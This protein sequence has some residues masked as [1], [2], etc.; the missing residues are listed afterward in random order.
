[1]EIWPSTVAWPP[2]G[3]LSW[4]LGGAGGK[5]VGRPGQ[6]RGSVLTVPSERQRGTPEQRKKTLGYHFLIRQ[7][8]DDPGFAQD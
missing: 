3:L 7:I 2:L 6:V 1:M 8:G 5:G 4:E